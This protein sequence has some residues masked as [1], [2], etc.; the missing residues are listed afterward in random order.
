MMGK[1]SRRAWPTNSPP[2]GTMPYSPALWR[3]LSGCGGIARRLRL[4]LFQLALLGW[5]SWSTE[6]LYDSCGL[7]YALSLRLWRLLVWASGISSSSTIALYYCACS[8]E[9]TVT[10]CSPHPFVSLRGLLIQ[11]KVLLKGPSSLIA[12]VALKLRSLRLHPPRFV[13]PCRICIQTKVS[14]FLLV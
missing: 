12:R 3:K 9:V 7:G 13:S 11:T 4:E 14:L 8:S 6:S 1:V 2:W 5:R 10:A